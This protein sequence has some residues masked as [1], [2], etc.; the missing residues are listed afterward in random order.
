M[1]RTSALSHVEARRPSGKSMLEQ[2]SLLPGGWRR[3]SI[4][5][6]EDK[7]EEGRPGT[8]IQPSEMLCF[9]GAFLPLGRPDFI[10]A[11]SSTDTLMDLFTDDLRVFTI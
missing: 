7:R 2:S 6:K 8:E 1:L 5:W 9:P 4:G 11:Q 10:I 3:G